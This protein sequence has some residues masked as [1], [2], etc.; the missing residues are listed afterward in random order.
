MITNIEIIF[1][2]EGE[3]EAKIKWIGGESILVY[4]KDQ[5]KYVGLLKTD[6]EIRQDLADVYKVLTNLIKNCNLNE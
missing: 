3:N 5:T 1:G 2:I 6:T 4:D